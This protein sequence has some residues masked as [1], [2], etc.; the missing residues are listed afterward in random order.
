[1][2]GL[3]NAAPE[4]GGGLGSNDGLH[5]SG[6]LTR[7]HGVYIGDHDG[8]LFNVPMC[9]FAHQDN[10][11]SSGEPI[12]MPAAASRHADEECVMLFL[13]VKNDAHGQVSRLRPVG[14]SVR[15]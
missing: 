8:R 13:S 2:S 5:A 3:Q 12:K 6:K 7:C 10:A 9:I 1:M 4:G 11:I 15:A 14:Q